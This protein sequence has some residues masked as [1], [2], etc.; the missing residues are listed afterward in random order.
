MRKLLILIAMGALLVPALAGA[1]SPTALINEDQD[2]P[3]GPADNPI[4]SI[5]SPAVNHN[6]GYAFGVTTSG[7]EGTISRYWGDAT[8]GP[9]A[10]IRSEATIGIFTQTAFESFWGFSDEGEVAY[11]PTC[12]N[13]ESG[14]TGL[15]SVWYADTWVAMEEEPYPFLEGWFWR[16]AS[17][18]GSTADGTPYFVG[19]ITDVQGGTTQNRGLFYGIDGAPVLVGG[20]MVPGLDDPLDTASTISFDVRYSANGTNYICEVQTV[21]EST[22]NNH[23]VV[24]GALLLIDGQPVSEGSP[25]PAAAGG[26]PGENWDNFDYMGITETG[27][28]FFTGDTDGDT[29]SD[30]FIC[31]NGMIMW[32][33]GDVIDGFPTANT[34]ERAYMNENGDVAF[35]WDVV[36]DDVDTE[37]LILNGE[38]L[39]TQNEE[40]DWTGD[41]VADPG[42][43]LNDF[44]GTAALV[45]GDR[46]DEG[47]VA[48]YFTADVE[49]PAGAPAREPAEP[50]DD[51]DAAGAPELE[52]EGTRAELEAGYVLYSQQVVPVMLASFDV[53]PVADGVE[54]SW[55]AN[56]AD[57]GSF[58]VEARRG[59][60]VWSLDVI[61]QGHGR[62]VAHDDAS[63]G[64]VT[65]NLYFHG[66]GSRFLLGSESVD[67]NVPAVGLTLHGAYPNPFNP[68]TKIAFS[69][70]RTQNVRVSVYRIDGTLVTELADEVFTSG[71]HELDWNGRDTAGNAVP[72]GTYFARV[73]SAEGMRTGKLMLV[74]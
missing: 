73:E 56:G 33:E 29:A 58:A 39:L 51:L 64:S 37:A 8:G 54:L 55:R 50:I 49:Q 42:Y 63:S 18:A 35:V 71:R 30:E 7:T 17:R 15:D 43:V 5:T 36:V 1:Q 59:T 69:V 67:L 68:A 22:A 40:V 65:Y 4:T 62:Y 46:D 9:G 12:N 16:F 45:V 21:G 53:T 48:L 70:G 31:M 20:D 14:S 34:I 23:I 61:G 2:L 60:E 28:Y 25:V 72:S 57:G 66:E 26:L 52:E 44:T 24:S 47:V 11:S 3:G 74:K 27:D 32:R 41:G 10:L 38:I 6:G 19:G 13:N